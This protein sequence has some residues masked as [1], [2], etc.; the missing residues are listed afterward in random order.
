VTNGLPLR[1]PPIH[2]CEL[3]LAELWPGDRQLPFERKLQ[4]RNLAEQGQFVVTEG[5]GDLVADPQLGQPQHRRLPQR[6]HADSEF[7]IV[8]GA[9]G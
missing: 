2:R 7:G 5:F 6:Q 8:F 9:L 4:I 1:S 3:H